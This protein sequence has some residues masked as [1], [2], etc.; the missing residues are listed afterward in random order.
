MSAK[1]F[2]DPIHG[3]IELSFL[4]CRVLDTPQFQ[5]LRDISQLGGV[6]FVFPG[7]ASKRFEHSI[8]VAHLAKSFVQS[9][10]KA[11]PELNITDQDVLCVELAGL[12]HDIGHGPFSHLFDGKVLPRL[13]AKGENHIPG[14]A[15]EFS[16]EHASIALLDL[17]IQENYLMPDF[18]AHGLDE[19]DI[20]FIQELILGDA[21]DAPPGFV[22]NGR[23][24]GKSFLYD[25]VA[26]KRNGIDVD[27]FDYFARDCHVLGVTKSFDASRLMRFARVYPVTRE[28]TTLPAS[29]STLN[30][31]SRGSIPSFEAWSESAKLS[32]LPGRA[33]KTF[34]SSGQGSE[35]ASSS[36]PS[37]SSSAQHPPPPPPP[38]PGMS[39]YPQSRGSQGS[40]T[41]LSPVPG[42]ATRTSLEICFHYKEVLPELFWLTLPSPTA[43]THSLIYIHPTPPH[44]PF[45][46]LRPQAWNI[47]ELFHTRYALHKRAYQH[48]IASS[49]ELM[50]AEAL[51][52]ADPHI[53]IP[54][55]KNQ[56]RR[57]SECPFDM[58][59]YWR[60]GEYLLRSIQ[61]SDKPELAESRAVISRLFRRDLFACAVEIL[62]S[63]AQTREVAKGGADGVKEELLRIR[64]AMVQQGS[65][66]EKADMDRKQHGNDKPGE[67]PTPTL[68]YQT[69]QA[70]SDHDVFC[71]V[72][73]VGYGKGG[74]NPV[75]ELTTFYLPIK[76]GEGGGPQSSYPGNGA[77]VEVGVV[78][79]DSVSR[80]IP[81]EYEETYVRLF[82][83]YK[84]QKSALGIMFKEWCR[85][86][87]LG[88]T[89]SL[90]P[91][92]PACT[93][94]AG[95]KRPRGSR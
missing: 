48:K 34:A 13:M 49:V 46:H 20:H 75:S 43:P 50:I 28:I 94:S 70:L 40:L 3:H 65:V 16:H 91:L 6:Y 35:E 26:N 25:I 89:D 22:W 59:A 68:L 88:C 52:L 82:C 55:L 10:R 64:D 84:S 23:G 71:V 60:L 19:K 42:L 69:L 17:L 31:A 85:S 9:L 93:P 27:K 41:S 92:S 38:Q 15:H 58:H 72:V 18:R 90:T 29:G 32:A 5:R 2:N 62:L 56:P 73:K 66:V 4:A 14:N 53:T 8:G 67:T 81:R 24:S 33:T 54:G 45:T 95:T 1:T 44:T 21:S 76:Q 30:G 87:E 86:L 7:A 79:Q 57:M 39:P 47:F 12:C 80:L 77:S 78:P 63:A 83:R 74:L 11:Q 37:T 51:I 36:S 61:H